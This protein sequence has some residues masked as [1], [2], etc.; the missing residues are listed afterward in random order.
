[1]DK[2]KRRS[3]CPISVALEIFGD[4]WTLLVIRDIIFKNKNYYGEF[5]QSEERI[6]TNILASRLMLLEETSIVTKQVD[7]NNKTKYV[8]KLTEKGLD[9][10]PIL[11]DII[12]W[13]DT[14]DP[15]TAADKEF[16]QQIKND[17]E[18]LIENILEDHKK[19]G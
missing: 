6:A 16:V 19:I 10:L 2:I 15:N 14:Y 1:M 4:K 5:L 12:L 7:L 9:L 17:R 8:Y 18:K 3:N 11:I 13:S